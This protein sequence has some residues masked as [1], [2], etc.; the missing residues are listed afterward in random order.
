MEGKKIVCKLPWWWWLPLLL[1]P[2][3]FMFIGKSHIESD[4]T[5]KARKTLVGLGAAGGAAQ[6]AKISGQ[7]ITL[8]GPASAEAAARKA[9]LGINGVR[10]VKYI[11]DADAP[12][13]QDTAAET[14]PAAPPATDPA[15]VETTV[16]ETT[17]APTT[18]AETTAAPTTV[19]AAVAAP[20]LNVVAKY[21]GTKVVLTGAVATEAQKTQIFEA[22]K[23]TWTE[24]NV[25]NQLTVNGSGE[26]PEL[27]TAVKG[28]A[29]TFDAMKANLTTGEATLADTKLTVT[30]SSPSDSAK[31]AIDATVATASGTSTVTADAPQT[32]K[33][34]E[35]DLNKLNS[36]KGINFEVNSN[37]ITADSKTTLD[38]AAATINEFFAASAAEKIEIG[39]HT[40]SDG[41]DAAN[42]ALSERRAQAVLAYMKDKGVDITRVT[43]V[44]YGETKPIAENITKA[45]KAQNRRIEFKVS[46]S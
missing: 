21:D 6:F 7:D 44:G 5:S 15:P 20:T 13:V 25:D 24:A 2:L 43:A 11:A 8:R 41:K 4:L 40:D 39:G 10:H 26:S 36:L 34:L 17:I 33:A 12:V 38:E 9:V 28:L 35:A 14:V 23:Q 46:G 32:A 27:D 31:A 45:G 1:I 18:V 16:A 22:A 29:S 19:A 42:Q 30:G 3:L 37:V